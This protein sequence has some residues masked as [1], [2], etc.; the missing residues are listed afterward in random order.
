MKHRVRLLAIGLLAALSACGGGGG[1]ATTP[2]AAPAPLLVPLP[3]E[4]A[5]SGVVL[6]PGAGQASSWRV[7]REWPAGQLRIYRRSGDA[8]VERPFAAG[9]HSLAVQILESGDTLYVFGYDTESNLPSGRDPTRV[10][11]GIDVW[12]FGA[13]E[14]AT[15]T[16]LA[17]GLSL[18]GLDNLV[19]ARERAGALD[20][21]A[22]DRCVHL[23]A[24]GVP[25]AW[26]TAALAGYEIVELRFAEEEAHA[27][28]RPL[29]DHETGNRATGM[30]PYAIARLRTEGA[31]LQALPADCVPFALRAEAGAPAWSCA[32]S[33]ADF[34]EILRHDIAR[35][36]HHGVGDAGLP[37]T[38]GRIAWSQVYSLSAALHLD[39]AHLPRLAGARDWSAERAQMRQALALIARH[40]AESGYAARR[41][42][43]DRSPVLFALHLGRI[44]HLLATAQEQGAGS[45]ET[46]AALAALRAAL[47]ALDGTAEAPI[48]EA[49][50]ATLGYRRGIPFWADGANVPHNYVSGYVLGLLASADVPSAQAAR[51][52]ALLRPLQVVE[53]IGSESI[54]HYWWGRGRDGWQAG[55]AVSVNT[56][57]Y[58][59]QP[60]WAHITYRS[61]DA[62]AVLRLASVAPAEVGPATAQHL[63]A[64]VANGELLPFVNQELVRLGLPAALDAAVARR[65]A[66]SAAP[67][68]LQSQV[69][70]LEALSTR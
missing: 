63:R 5:R 19:Y 40:Q 32:A 17:S 44:A 59:G 8:W 27:I 23:P 57:T 15:P 52:A 14:A 9:A 54:W 41:Y 51:A 38:E 42:S 6:H 70:A 47:V 24:A 28:V 7:Q 16:L 29:D 49:G 22:I 69:W 25:A 65:H 55:D 3:D 11:E 67:W 33:S 56:P 36:P 43:L 46:A 61:M 31:S 12:R 66:R 26:N 2:E 45:P 10:R 37:N 53:S 39:P 1:E 21:C 62:M 34:A 13:A 20:A 64:L 60:G 58:A 48:V 30:P 35:Q 18:G 68:E 50:Y 4:G